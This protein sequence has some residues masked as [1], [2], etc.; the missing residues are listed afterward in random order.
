MQHEAFNEMISNQGYESTG[1]SNRL[2]KKQII[3][4]VRIIVIFKHLLN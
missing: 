4:Y 2:E 1:Q 3:N